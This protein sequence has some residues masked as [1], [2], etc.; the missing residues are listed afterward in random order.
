MA[1]DDPGSSEREWGIEGSEEEAVVPTVE[2]KEGRSGG[3]GSS[4][5]AMAGALAFL[6]LGARERAER[7]REM[8]REDEQGDLGLHKK[9]GRGSSA[10]WA[11]MACTV[12]GQSAGRAEHGMG[13]GSVH[14]TNLG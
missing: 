14:V 13:D 3:R 2:H 10:A 9:G 11:A 8:D 4:E 1:P 6:R 12:R 7:G 5:P